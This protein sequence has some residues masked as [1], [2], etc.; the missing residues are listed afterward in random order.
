MAQAAGVVMYDCN[1]DAEMTYAKHTACAILLEVLLHMY[2]K[3]P[4]SNFWPR[5]L[6]Q[7]R[8]VL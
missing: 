7:V 8:I 5:T 3:T 2:K 6:V 1:S 4:V